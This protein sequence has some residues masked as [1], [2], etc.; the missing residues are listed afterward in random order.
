[1]VQGFVCSAN[2]VRRKDIGAP[3]ETR[4]SVVGG[5]SSDRQMDGVSLATRTHNGAVDGVLPGQGVEIKDRTNEPHIQFPSAELRHRDISLLRL[6][7][8]NIYL[9]DVVSAVRG[10]DL[11]D[12]RIYIGAVAGSVHLTGCVGCQI[13]AA[14][15]QV[16]IHASRACSFM[17]RTSTGP[18]IEDS[19][20]LSF[21]NYVLRYPQCEKH[22]AEAGLP[23]ASCSAWNDV[24]DFSWLREE[25]SPNWCLRKSVDEYTVQLDES[26]D[27][28]H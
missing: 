25:S 22:I 17:L 20:Q 7:G 14:A 28:Q 26:A 18:I 4:E 21:G 23:D 15:R 11:V 5:Q 8:C 27:L 19:T 6:R 1:L 9:C 16:R 13:F 3:I 10:S 12:C 24:Q 2:I